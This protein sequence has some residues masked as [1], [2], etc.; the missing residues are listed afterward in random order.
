MRQGARWS[1][2][3]AYS[4][5]SQRPEFARDAENIS[6]ADQSAQENATSQHAV[7]G[8]RSQLRLN[9][10]NVELMKYHDPMGRN[11]TLHNAQGGRSFK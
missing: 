11:A 3:I 2:A 7:Q 5:T 6:E 1:S 10:L 4:S 9:V 8:R